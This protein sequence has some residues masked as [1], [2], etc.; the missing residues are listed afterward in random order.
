MESLGV[1]MQ[2]LV[3]MVLGSQN[4]GAVEQ[5]AKQF[6]LDK[7]QTSNALEQLLPSLKK[8]IQH[9]TQQQGGLESLLGALSN[10]KN[11]E[12][13]EQPKRLAEPQAVDNGNAILGHLLGSKETS[14]QVAEQ[15]SSKTGIDSGILKQILP[16]AA[17]MLMGSLTKETNS[18]QSQQGFLQGLLD[19][20][21]DG[22]VL[23]DVAGMA[24]KLF[25]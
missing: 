16:L 12:Y 3:N 10:S 22:S 2:D 4:S 1:G 17:N 9:N 8:G 25:R 15:A 13:V 23:D 20:D 6:N 5:I 11:Q 19:S 14:R 24:S 18:Q 21:N 7:Q